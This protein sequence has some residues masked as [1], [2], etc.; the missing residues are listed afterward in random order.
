[1]LLRK[2]RLTSMRAALLL[3]AIASTNVA[4]DAIAAI[5][6]GRTPATFAVS[7]SGAATYTIPIW[8]P[9]G[10][11]DVQLQL[12]LAYNSRTPNGVMG[13]GWSLSGLSAITRCNKTWAQ[14]GAPQGVLLTLNDRFCLDGQQLKL[15]SAPGTYG[16][17]GSVYATEIE[18]FSKIE[19]SGT[20]GNGPASFKVTTKNGLIY[21]YGTTTDSQIK[22][23]GGTTIRTWALSRIRDRVGVDG[24]RISIS[25]TNDTTNNSYRVA[26]IAYPTTA[27]G[28]GPFYEVVF[29]YA[30]RPTNDVPSS[31]SSG[32]ASRELN[33]LTMITIRNFGSP[34]PTKIYNLAYSQGTATNRSRLTS[35]QECSASN[36]FPATTIAYQDG[37]TGWTTTL[38][39]TLQTT[40]TA[41]GVAPIPVDLNADGKTD[42]LYPKV[43]TSSTSRWWAI[44]ATNGGFGSAI[45][46]GIVTD[47]VGLE[48]V[49]AFSGTGQQQVLMKLGGYWSM[50]QYNSA[51][52]FTTT[53]TGVSAGGGEYAA[54]DYDG[55]G[56]LDLASVV[57]NEIRVR[58]NITVPPGAVAFASTAET[59][60]T[61][62][63]G[64]SIAGGAASR[65]SLQDFDGNGKGDLY[66]TTYFNTGFGNMIRGEILRS[67]GFGALASHTQIMSPSSSPMAGDWNADGCTDIIGGHVYLSDCAGG[68]VIISNAGASTAGKLAGDWDGDGRTDAMYVN[69]SN[70]TWYVK[71]S[72]GEGYLPAI[73]TGTPAPLGS[74]WFALEKNGDGLLDIAYVDTTASNTM[75]YRVHSGVAISAD[76]ASSFTDGFGINQSPSYKS[77]AREIYTKLSD[78]VFPQLDIQEPLYVVAQVLASDGIGGTYQQDFWYYGAHVNVQGRGFLGFSNRRTIDTRNS[79]HVN[80]QFERPFPYTGMPVRRNVFQPNGTTPISLWTATPAAQDFG[81]TGPEQRK[82]PFVASTTQQRFEFGGP[83]D[84][85]LIQEDATQYTY[86][87]GFGNPTNVYTTITDKDPGSPFLNS[88][89]QTTVTQT[90]QND[91][92]SHCLGLPLTMSVTSAV[93]SQTAQT[94][95]YSYPNNNIGLCRVAQE[96]VE[97]Y[98][99][100]LKVTTTLGF[101]TDCGNLESIQVIGSNPPDGTPMPARTT[102]LGF[103]TRCQLPET[104]TNALDQDSEFTYF[105][106]FGALQTSAD[107]NDF[108][109]TWEIDDFG[110]RK[111]EDR[112]DGTATVWTYTPCTTPPCWGA[113]DLRLRVT[114]DY[115]DTTDTSFNTRQ[116]HY[117]GMDRLRSDETNRILGVW[118]K[119]ETLYD[120]LGRVVTRYQ[121]KSSSSNGHFAWTYDE[122]GRV[123]NEKLFQG[124]G[125][126]DRT[127]TYQYSGRT[128]TITDPLLRDTKHVRD[129]VGRLR[130][131]VDPTPGGTT[132]YEYDVFGN[133]NRI[134]DPINAISGGTYNL[135][136][137][138]TQWADIDR[139]T[140]NFTPNSLNELISWTD[141]KGQSFSAEYDDLGRMKNR[142]EAGVISEWVW[143][144]NPAEN[145]IGSLKSKTG[146]G[147]LEELFYDGAGR[148]SN[149]RITTDQVYDYDYAYNL[150]GAIDTITY[151]TSPIPADQTGSRYKIK[152]LYSFGEPFQIQD[153][154][155]TPATTTLWS[156]TAANDYSSATAETLGANLISVTSGYRPWTNELTS[157]TSG[158]S[159]STTNRQNLAYE[160][161]KVGNLE[162]RQDLIQGLTEVFAPDGLNRVLSSTLNTVPNLA[163]SYD[164]AGN[165][166]TKT[167]I[168]GTYN[169][170]TAQT[171]CSYYSHSQPHAVRNAGGV[172]YCYDQNGNVVKRGGLTQ[173]WASF[174]LPTTLQ[175]TVDGSTYQSQFFYGPNHKRWKQ[176][177]TYSNGTETTLYVGGLLEKVTSTYTGL[178]YWRHYVPTPSG[179]TAIVSRNSN[180][181]TWTTFALSDHL[182][183]SDALLNGSGAFKVRESF[184]AFGARRGSNWSSSTPPDW[185]GI[186]DTTRRGFTFHEMLDNIGLIHMNGRVYDPT[187][188]RF[189]SVDPLIPDLA[190]SQL[191]NPFSYVGNRP[192]SFIDPSGFGPD[193]PNGGGGGL[194]G[195]GSFCNP[196]DNDGSPGTWKWWGNLISGIGKAIGG[197]FGLGSGPPPPPPARTFPGT[198]AQNGVNIC[199]PGMSSPSCGGALSAGDG[200][201]VFQGPVFEKPPSD[202]YYAIVTHPDQFGIW[203]IVVAREGWQLV[204]Q[205]DDDRDSE[206]AGRVLN[207]ILEEPYIDP[208]EHPE[209]SGGRYSAISVELTSGKVLGGTD[210]RDLVPET[211]SRD[212]SMEAEEARLQRD[213]LNS[214]P[215]DV[216]RA[217]YG[218]SDASPEEIEELKRNYGINED[219]TL[220][221]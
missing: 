121:P 86:G 6:A 91:T 19:A 63:G 7:N 99:P 175:A 162:R 125:A 202:R 170:T 101:D 119:I 148:L 10:V 156:L 107:P 3:S 155:Q 212:P 185:A 28:Q 72:T 147:Y 61:Y 215:D 135:R 22:P 11:G 92:G 213:Y 73:S 24:N 207:S 123:K 67:N 144:S 81:A 97:P 209:T 184:D 66:F 20:S 4:T 173:T 2:F 78:A 64:W 124:S 58:R 16:Q 220:K 166:V 118:T 43:N 188:G 1:M 145:N 203:V 55:D 110:R 40:S 74:I 62:T 38:Y 132:E 15:V 105:Y 179:L 137:F 150:I 68:F 41:I 52:Y 172:V 31:Y 95:Q 13:M 191:V 98:I 51:G 37:S 85:T 192:L 106:D 87:D 117:D 35:L 190:D 50:V 152:Y 141:A 198:S 39:T 183:S 70:N 25:Y 221:K 163:M 79:L 160:W 65:M 205:Y 178:T 42:I 8:T 143:G 200:A 26:S 138:K 54:V 194:P 82:F 195:C 216:R 151:P 80:D 204:F 115:R 76:L 210:V 180:S 33:R 131:V 49:G 130:H 112:P 29:A 219:W 153:I 154:T 169:Y 167:G 89:W 126:L 53:S 32:F 14:D 113:A 129:V 108:L 88:T 30:T 168:S 146:Y 56:L 206:D 46:T 176:I 71:R 208:Y 181:S 109:T 161:D 128:I 159:G 164:A 122:L 211:A 57:G 177:S 47:N 48:I 187:V 217:L 45:N 139:G 34:S 75:K 197:L 158:V 120:A 21:E 136:G 5:V 59:I 104:L 201:D 93:P 9:P 193:D 111:R 18:N 142:T 94:R 84:A 12:A 36:C 174:N 186:A 165:I 133:L 134:I 83:I 100:S 171:G 102:T 27:T 214:L 218:M 103:G 17:P 77:I 140:W 23:G 114:E 189:M 157:M 116:L 149:R 196:N 69:T 44:L 182:G 90:F 96:V 127:T 199:D 60:F